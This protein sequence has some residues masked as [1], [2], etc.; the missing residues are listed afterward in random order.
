MVLCEGEAA[1]SSSW[2]NEAGLEIV[3]KKEDG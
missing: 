2:S 3:E 1:V